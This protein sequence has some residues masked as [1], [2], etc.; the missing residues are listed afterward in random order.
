M[1]ENFGRKL[2]AILIAFVIIGAIIL[3]ILRGHT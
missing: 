3:L 2:Q 1:L